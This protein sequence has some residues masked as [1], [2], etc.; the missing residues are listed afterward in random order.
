MFSNRAKNPG[1]TDLRPFWK[2]NGMQR[3]R[4]FSVFHTVPSSCCCEAVVYKAN[5][6]EPR[7][8]ATKRLN[9]S[10]LLGAAAAARN[11]TFLSALVVA[12]YRG[13]HCENNPTS[14][15][16]A[17]KKCIECKVFQRGEYNT[18]ELCDQ[19]CSEYSLKKVGAIKMSRNSS[20]DTRVP[21][22]VSQPKSCGEV[23]YECLKFFCVSKVPDSF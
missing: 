12:Q 15:C 9:S 7:S 21:T 17:H 4:F 22:S 8:R 14:S 19:E 6:T 5:Y 3:S 23:Q 2:I 10:P 16:V 1:Q 13:L 18:T 11:I 20:C